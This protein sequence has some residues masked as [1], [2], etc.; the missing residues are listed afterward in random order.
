[1]KFEELSLIELVSLL[2]ERKVSSVEVTKYFIE[3]INEKKNLNA[4]LE[5]YEDA[6][7]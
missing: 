4:V 2:H 6:I 1:M 3:R 5:V 7:G